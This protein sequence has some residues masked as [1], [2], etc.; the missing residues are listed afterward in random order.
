MI[1]GRERRI[2]DRENSSDDSE[3]FY[4]SLSVWEL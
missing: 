3:T 2:L 1:A 4:R